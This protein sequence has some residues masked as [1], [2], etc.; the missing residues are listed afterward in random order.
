MNLPV[1]LRA[2]LHRS[3]LVMSGYSANGFFAITV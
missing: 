2:R 3:R 1:R